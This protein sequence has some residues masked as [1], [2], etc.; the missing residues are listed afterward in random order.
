L[1]LHTSSGAVIVDS[2]KFDFGTEFSFTSANTLPDTIFLGDTLFMGVQ[3]KPLTFATTSDTIRVYNNSSQS[4]FS[5]RVNGIGNSGTLVVVPSSANFGNVLVG[6]SAL[7]TIKAYATGANIIVSA[8]SMEAG[9]D[10]TVVSTSGIPVTLVAGVDTLFVDVKFKPSTFGPLSDRFIITN[11]SLLNPL[12]VNV[13]G[14]GAAGTLA[15]SPFGYDFG[16]VPVNSTAQQSVKIFA[17]SGKVI[18]NN[19]A[20]DNGGTFTLT[21]G[22]LPDTLASG[23]T[24]VATVTFS[25]AVTG[26]LRDTL[27]IGNNSQTSSVGI[28]FDGTGEAGALASD[29]TAYDF[30]NIKVGNNAERT[31][32]IYTSTGQVIIAGLAL[33]VSGQYTLSYSSVLPLTLNTG[34]TLLASVRFAP[35][36]GGT[37]LDTLY[38][39]NNSAVSLYG[40]DL[41]GFGVV[42]SAPNTFALKQPGNDS[43]VNTKTPIFTWEGRGDVD[44]DVLSYTLQISKNINFSSVTQFGGI[45]DTVFTLSSPLDSLGSY[46]WRVSAN[47]N[48]GGITLSNT[49]SFSVDAVNPGLFVGVLASTIQQNYIEVYVHSDEALNSLNGIFVLRDASGTAVDTDTLAITNL[50]GLLYYVP[51]KLSAN[52]ELTMTITGVDAVGNGTTSVQVYDI[53]VVT[54]KTPVALHTSGGL[55]TVSGAK[56]SVDR[57]GYLLVLS[58]STQGEL[59]ESL[60]KAIQRQN[61]LPK[62]L[63]A[64]SA[65]PWTPV[66]ETVK[67]LS[68][69]EIKKT[70][71]VTMKYDHEMIRG[72]MDRYPGFS[73]SKIGMYREEDTRWIY[74]GGE[75]ERGQVSAKVKTLGVIGLFYNPEHVDLPK[76]IE[77]S[78]NYPNPFN[79][80]TSI[81]F[82][83]PDEG[84]VKLVIYN[85]LGQKVR[86]LINESRSAGYHTAVW[87]GK[88]DLG[89]EVASGLYIYRIESVR[90]A[91]SKKMLLIK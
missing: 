79:P 75:G 74:E 76:S 61:E 25:P 42:N 56:G 14:I 36:A 62:A 69:V 60:T 21:A 72:L 73:E 28:G 41:S 49:E 81:R 8:G 29:V 70:L 30:G 78:Q 89:Q 35:T 17:A 65:S 44:G 5:V 67:I 18:I 4:V 20:L 33:G 22:T 54:A 2:L 1:K 68:T 45:A 55:I 32:K 9:G 87:N 85:V 66:G 59:S 26:I 84:K 39:T 80:S 38:V 52:G 27:R 71:T 50:S 7:Q 86:E 23:D 24:L 58:R 37:D 57:S 51:Y 12:K 31:F 91:V 48:Q 83:L 6:D 16:N 13:T 34:D 46:F 11:N 53:S 47:D 77:L 88:N 82:G 63:L 90:G 43:T 40:V 64:E 10:F 19:L 15:A 3:Y